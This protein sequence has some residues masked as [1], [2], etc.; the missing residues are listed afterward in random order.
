M[1]KYRR[2]TDRKL[3]FT[4]ELLEQV[5]EKLLQG[6]SKRSI[7][8]S[9]GVHEATLRKRLKAGTVPTS[10]GRF[11][12]VFTP[13]MEE[14]LAIYCRDLD[15]TFYGL[16]LKALGNL[17]FEYAERNNLNH[18]FN[19]EKRSAGKDWV[20]SFCKRHK[21]S[22]RVPEK[23]SL[24]RAAGFNRPQ[25][26]LFF[27]NLRQILNEKKILPH[28]LYNMD[29]SGI[30]TVP[31]KL[32]KVVA[33][34]GKRTVGKIV[35]SE[36]GQLITAVCCMGA[37]GQYIPPALVFPR[38]RLKAEL[39]DRAPAGTL[40]LVSDSGFITSELFLRWLDHFQTFCK[41]SVEDPVLLVLDNHSSHVSLQAVM[42]CRGLGINMLSLP[43]HCSHKIQPLDKNFFGPLKS[44]YA[45]ECDKW[46]VN[47]PGRPITMFQ[48][49]ELFANAYSRIASIERAI[50]AF[51][52]CGIFPYNPHVFSEEEF[53]PAT[54]TDQPFPN[55]NSSAENSNP[56]AED[57]YDSDEDL[58]LSVL[59][60]K[61]M[62]NIPTKTI[63][64]TPVSRS[65][66]SPPSTPL[67]KLAHSPL[68]STSSRGKQTPSPTLR[69]RNSPP[70][71]PPQNSTNFISPKLI[72]PLPKALPRAAN[73]R[74]KKKSVLL[75]A[76]PYKSELEEL[77]ACKQAKTQKFKQTKRKYMDELK[78]PESIKSQNQISKKSLNS[79]SNQKQILCPVCYEI[80]ED[81]PES[82]WIQC[83]TC[84]NW[85]HEDCTAYSGLGYYICHIC[86][87]SE[88]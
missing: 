6:M 37:T 23:T 38:K 67:E 44:A 49:A 81:P 41:S 65:Q 33:P 73:A 47:N 25:V 42:K 7:A 26:E 46:H 78:S 9:I 63:L 70:S 13:E 19:K 27:R 11:K 71:T 48:I 29:E 75:T 40:Q 68:P 60:H 5:K 35:S 17:V 31:N 1:G 4:A 66:N 54:V 20:Y 51:E 86:D 21:L 43:P 10:L 74:K 82:D 24:A 55:Q 50:K 85:F 64:P 28:R 84:K 62:E 52:I 53:A 15:K 3:I 32:P 76:S 39:T 87:D 57:E 56:R 8:D 58:P 18:R 12:L 88:D 61:L 2:K 45:E 80:Y 79:P 77:Q 69:V 59:Q 34:R 36:R 30:L 16:T 72:K 22:L 14:E 83:M